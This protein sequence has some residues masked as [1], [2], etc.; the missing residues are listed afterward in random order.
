MILPGVWRFTAIHP[1]WESDHDGWEPEVA[2]WAIATEAGLLL[3][4]PLIT[5]DWDE[6]DGLVAQHGC[7]AGIVRTMH[8]HQRS[9]AEAAE[10]YEAEVWAR[11]DPAERHLAHGEEPTPGVVAFHVPRDDELVIWLKAHRALIAGD[12]LLRDRDGTL[13]RCPD[14]WLRRD[15]GPQP[16]QHT[17]ADLAEFGPAH[18]LVSHGP[19]RLSDGDRLAEIASG[20]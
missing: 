6:L 10:R 5:A 16:L 4:D 2:W 19:H 7:C 12:V 3:V 9:I 8:F 13:G 1:E 20:G 14:G 18:V 17:L 11:G 15:G